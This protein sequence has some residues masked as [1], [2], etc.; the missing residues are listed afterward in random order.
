MAKLESLSDFDSHLKMAIN[1][2]DT[3]SRLR[4][5]KPGVWSAEQEVQFSQLLGG[6]R[7]LTA[8]VSSLVGRNR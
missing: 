1:D 5:G 3:L 8:A 4:G 2:I 6:L 7:H